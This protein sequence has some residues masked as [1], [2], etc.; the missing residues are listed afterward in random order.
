MAKKKIIVGMSTL[1][2]IRDKGGIYVDKTRF[3]DYLENNAGTSVPVFLRPRRFG[4]SLT[5]SVLHSYYDISEKDQF[6]KNFKGTWI[7]D[8]RTPLASS[9]YVIHFD[10]SNVASDPAQMNRS[11]IISV[12][13]SISNFTDKYPEQSLAREELEPSLYKNATEL[14][15]K[16]LTKF[17]G[18]VGAGEYLY[19]IIDEYDHFANE[20]LSKDKE[21]FKDITSTAEGHEGLIK[22]FYAQLKAYYRGNRNGGIDRFFITGVS[23]VSLDSVTSGFNIATNISSEL[24]FGS[25]IGFTHDELSVVIDESVDFSLLPNNITKSQIIQIMEENFDGYSFNRYSNEKLFNS[26]LCL[27]Y[28]RKMLSIK[29]IPDLNEISLNDNTSKLRGML[30]LCEDYVREEIVRAMFNK[31]PIVTELPDKMNLNSTNYFDKSQIVSLLYHLGYL[32]IDT[33][34]SREEGVTSFVIP[35]KVYEKLF[36]DYCRL[37]MG[38]SADAYKDLSSMYEESADITPLME[39]IT[40]QIETK[41]NP[42]SLGKFTE[43]AL[44][45]ICDSIIN[46]SRKRQLNSYIEFYTGKGFADVFVKNI[47]P[48]GHYFLLELKY[49]HKKDDSKSA[50][51]G[52]LAE[53]R[54]EIERYLEGTVLKEKVGN[55]PLDCYAIVFVGSECRLCQKIC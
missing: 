30:N 49:L 25:M 17:S 43:M 36:L 4:K 15:T 1:S 21:A 29:T 51:E 48:N 5:A 26:N 28:L 44:Q 38:Y 37:S 54:E 20:I 55:H 53:A 14:L 7:Y 9:Y 10:F 33:D 3:I 34:T 45:L 2:E 8:H 24:D 18:N 12:A 32:T 16:F 41:L 23:S 19:V 40:E 11:F 22:Q 31:R 39:I 35:N 52:K 27:D 13:A 50:V 47:Y 6:E 42:Q 46:N